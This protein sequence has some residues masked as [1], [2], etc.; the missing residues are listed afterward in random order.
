MKPIGLHRNCRNRRSEPVERGAGTGVGPTLASALRHQGSR[1]AAEER[2]R[3]WA[4]PQFIREKESGR[5]VDASG[6]RLYT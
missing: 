2:R 3:A 6:L 4:T 1:R 5:P